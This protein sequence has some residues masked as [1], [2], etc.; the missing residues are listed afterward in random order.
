MKVKIKEY[1][2]ELPYYLTLDEEY[3]LTDM[4][5]DGFSGSIRTDDFKSVYICFQSSAHLN[6]GSWEIVSE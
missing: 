2:G 5:S 6:G 1:F 3:E 4:D